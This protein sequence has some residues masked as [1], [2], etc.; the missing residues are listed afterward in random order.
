LT[1]F[2]NQSIEN[3]KIEL[4]FSKFSFNEINILNCE[5]SRLKTTADQFFIIQW[6]FK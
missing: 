2:E 1:D 5:I 6:Q 3:R 4:H